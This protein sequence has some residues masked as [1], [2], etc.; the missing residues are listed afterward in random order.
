MGVDIVMDRTLKD[1]R[2]WD[3]WLLGA[4]QTAQ[5]VELL[6]ELESRL[7]GA[8]AP[9]PIPLPVGNAGPAV[10]K[11]SNWTRLKKAITDSCEGGPAS[12]LDQNGAQVLNMDAGQMITFLHQNNFHVQTPETQSL[13][14][15]KLL[16]QRYG[17]GSQGT[18]IRSFVTATAKSIEELTSCFVPDL[19]YLPANRHVPNLIGVLLQIMGKGFH[20]SLKDLRSA[21]ARGNVVSN[22]N[23][24]SAL[25]TQL[26]DLIRQGDYKTEIQ[27]GDTFY[28]CTEEMFEFDEAI[29]GEVLVTEDQLKKRLKNQASKIKRANKKKI[30]QMQA[31]DGDAYATG[32]FNN[33][34][35]GKG[36][37]K[38]KDLKKENADL[39]FRIKKLEQAASKGQ[40]KGKG[41]NKY[42]NRQRDDR[43]DS[44]NNHASGNSNWNNY[45]SGKWNSGSGSYNSWNNQGKG[46]GGWNNSHY[47]GGGK[48][49]KY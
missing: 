8:V 2:D 20:S 25:E 47:N 26:N 16:T 36:K 21:L 13:D 37:G 29:G 49:K 5:S 17:K 39:H 40:G 12:F 14:K 10:K 28:T 43:R 18:S 22:E 45:N 27:G 9:A 1:P 23:L 48:G 32:E 24:I 15:N 6:D 46:N 42:D 4:K 31:E 19:R 35:G 7:P 30:K 38:G 11:R 33:P 44:W 3:S 34:K 41:G